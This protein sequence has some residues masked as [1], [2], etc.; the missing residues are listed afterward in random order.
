M[1]A[2]AVNP[3]VAAIFG[4][5]I[6]AGIWL[7]L[8]GLASRRTP[9]NE[10]L[11]GS[12]MTSPVV[13]QLKKA[14]PY[15]L[16]L[17]G[18][19]LVGLAVWWWTDWPVAGAAA[20][21]LTLWG[22]ALFGP[23]SAGRAAVAKSE[24]VAAWAESLAGTVAAGL[25]LSQALAAVAQAAPPELE[26][27]SARLAKA[28]DDGQPLEAALRAFAREVDD[29]ICSEA[30]HALIRAYKRSGDLAALLDRLASTARENAAMQMDTI[31]SRTRVRTA[32]RLPPH[33]RHRG[34][35][36]CSD[37]GLGPGLP[38][39]LRRA[40]GAGATGAGARR[41]RP[42]PG[43]AGPHGPLEAAAELDRPGRGVM[44]PFIAAV[45]GAL[46]GTGIW[47]AVAA[48]WP[49]RPALADEIAELDPAARGSALRPAK[50]GQ[51]SALAVRS[52]F[53]SE[54][55][56]A[57][58]ACLDQNVPWFWQTLDRNA[59]VAAVTGTVAGLGFAAVGGTSTALALLLAAAGVL[60]AVPLTIADLHQRAELE[61]RNYQRAL[62]V[63]LDQIAVSL[64]GGAGI[65]TALA[66]ALEI[67]IGAQFG[68]L[69]EAIHHGQLVRQSPWESIGILGE[70]ISSADYRQLAA[71][72]SLAGN[73]GARIKSA[74]I[75]R[76]ETM[77]A[78]R[79]AQEKADEA[80]KT[81]RMSLPVV[82]IAIW[83]LLFVTV[84]A[85]MVMLTGG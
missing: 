11:P 54:Q 13:L 28:L 41:L 27:Q 81:E 24:A 8:Y 9:E 51:L 70:Q 14:R 26:A 35:F 15:A 43:L 16:R 68:R 79:R 17:C 58:L 33:H 67:G 10:P 30:V 75:A 59:L 23:D 42:Q 52:G 69:R 76:S 25:G 57:D 71:S 46:I 48:M 1:G 56:M 2:M 3:L 31:A 78:K 12:D 19:A 29:E 64:S 50:A 53:P 20:G 36:D 22:R 7:T 66:E 84:P 61:R 32:S 65:D 4:A 72:L 37:R 38:H 44:N 80:S 63:L 74:L 39:L 34:R 47:V 83:V 18:A 45:F 82:A 60:I 85:S 40:D 49:W 55:T 5:G 73:E 62:T 6:G 21:L 77:R